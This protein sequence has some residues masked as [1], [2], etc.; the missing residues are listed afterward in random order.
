MATVTPHG[1]IAAAGETGSTL[2]WPAGDVSHIPYRVFT[3][4]QIFQAEQERIFRGPT[5]NYVG[6]EAEVPHEGD[7]KTTH[8]GEVP[9][10]LSRDRDGRLH[11]LINRCAH[12]GAL[13]L[14]EAFGSKKR[15][16]CIYHQWGYDP[17]GD[18]KAVP[19][20]AG[21]G[22]GGGLDERF[23]M[24]EHGLKRLRVATF[25]GLV[26]A[27]FSERTPPLE[28]YLGGVMPAVARVFDG[29]PLVVLGYLRQL[30]KANWKLYF[31]NTKDPYHAS[32]LHLFHATF[33]LYRSTM[34]GEIYAEPS[35]VGVLIAHG[36]TDEAK[37]D[38]YEREEISSYRK[39]YR[40]QEPALLD[41][42]WEYG[43]RVT[44]SI[45]TLFPSLVNHQIGNTIATRHVIPRAVDRFELTWTFVGY[46]DDP[47]E[48][49]EKRLLQ[50]NLVGPAGYISLEDVEALEIVQK[51]IQGGERETSFVEMGGQT[52]PFA[53]QPVPNLLSEA[54]IRGFWHTWRT[55]MGV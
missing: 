47:P 13:V 37:K 36:G 3:D 25:N 45:Q 48:L 41:I 22:C 40:L 34:K 2:D 35:G 19:F 17:N 27:S 1:S 52:P 14:R 32:L 50:A 55:L 5:W 53:A 8:I 11:V 24:A 21:A 6:L 29:R 44:N 46:A 7:Y 39:S 18:L 20:K 30:V 4:P 9:V 51:A 16:N 31:E 38:Q 49:R 28:E 15:F 26:F 42:A 43:D 54:A 23:A 33:G 12:R 10:I